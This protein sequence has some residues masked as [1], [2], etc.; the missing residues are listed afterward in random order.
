MSATNAL[1][2]SVHQTATPELRT[3]TNPSRSRREKPLISFLRVSQ[4]L[5]N[6]FSPFSFSGNLAFLV[7]WDLLPPN[8][9]SEMLPKNLK[10]F[11]LKL[12]CLAPYQVLTKNFTRKAE[13]PEMLKCHFGPWPLT[14]PGCDELLRIS[15]HTA[16]NN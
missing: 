12:K 8:F 2:K 7:S 16:R 6:S 11:R 1:T 3:S 9:A 4:T 14:N 13:M 10:H 5:P 15:E